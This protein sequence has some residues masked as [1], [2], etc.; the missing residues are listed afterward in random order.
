MQTSTVALLDE[1]AQAETAARAQRVLNTLLQ[2]AR[3]AGSAMRAGP[4]AR[5]AVRALEVMSDRDLRDIGIL[6]HQITEVVRRPR[7]EEDAWE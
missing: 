6:R 4:H 1:R 2:M 7:A 5:E 3:Y